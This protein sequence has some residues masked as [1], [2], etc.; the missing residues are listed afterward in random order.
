MKMTRR[1][2]IEMLIASTL[3][4][5]LSI[6]MIV[7]FVFASAALGQWRVDQN[8]ASYEMAERVN[9]NDK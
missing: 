4:V 7:S 5:F 3:I 6:A 9:Q 2:H 8:M 1:Q